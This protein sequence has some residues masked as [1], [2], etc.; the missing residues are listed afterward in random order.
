MIFLFNANDINYSDYYGYDIEQRIW[1]CNLLQSV[2]NT[3]TIYQGDIVALSYANTYKKLQDLGNKLFFDRDT[4]YLKKDMLAYVFMHE[5][6]YAWAIRNVP[7]DLAHKLHSMLYSDTGYLGMLK[8]N[9]A[10]PLHRWF[11][12]DT[13]IKKYKIYNYKIE[14]ITDIID[15][16]EY[17]GEIDF[18][19][20]SGFHEVTLRENEYGI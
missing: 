4:D 14:I 6:V 20:K 11:F 13:L 3:L 17:F 5:C 9:D 1:K 12:V 18:L 8:I 7:D 15:E 16:M 2:E 19:K 10:D